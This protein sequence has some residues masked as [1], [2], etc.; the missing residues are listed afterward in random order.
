MFDNGAEED[1]EELC[2]LYSLPSIFG[3]IQVKENE[4]GSASSMDGGEEE[5]V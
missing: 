5:H 2:D 4:V 1:I 3:I